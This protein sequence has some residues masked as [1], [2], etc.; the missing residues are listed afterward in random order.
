[1]PT[2]HRPL[3]PY[4]HP[5]P[6]PQAYPAHKPQRTLLALR[7]VVLLSGSV[8]PN[9]LSALVGR[10]MLDL[11]LD[12]SD[13]VLSHWTRQVGQLTHQRRPDELPLRVMLCRKAAIP[14]SRLKLDGVRLSVERDPI[15]FRGTGGVL[16]DLA[17]L[18]HDDDYLLVADAARL[19]VQPLTLTVERLAAVGGDVVLLADEHGVP[20]DI[21]LVRCAA[22]RHLPALGYV[23]FKEQALETIARR[24]HVTVLRQP[25]LASLSIRTPRLYL[26]AVQQ[27]QLGLARGLASA[28]SRGAGHAESNGLTQELSDAAPAASLADL[29]AHLHR[30][31]VC[32]DGAAVEPTAVLHN[33]VVLEGARI[34]AGAMVARSIVCGRA[35]VPAGCHFIDCLITPRFIQ[36]LAIDPE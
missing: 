5:H 17:Q 1:M 6:L 19:T 36:H 34:D 21:M 32:E 23:D 29:E 4:V 28:E 13:T 15:D 20:D 26:S 25:A 33:A 30:F 7:A 14:T 31:V 27:Y 11:P 22:L 12:Q 2:I 24:H 10:S 35:R 3:V 9:S 16:R 18:Y 8:Y